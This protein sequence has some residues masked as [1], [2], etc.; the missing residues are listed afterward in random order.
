[1]DRQFEPYGLSHWLV[2]ATFAV[3]AGLLVRAGRRHP[4]PAAAR[5]F[6]R[7]FA[8]VIGAL[9]VAIR[10]A[11]MVPPGLDRSVPLD[12]SDL[13]AVAAA[14]ALWT[15]RHWAFAMTYYWGLA[16]SSQALASP[17]HTGP[18]F[19]HYGFLAFW[20]IHLVVVWAAIYL[21]WGLGM[22]P[23]WRSYRITVAVTVVWAVV[24]FT[25]NSIAGTN[26]GFL[27]AKPAAVSL[28]DVLGPWPWYLVP[29]AVLVLGAWALLTWPW[30]HAGRRRDPEAG[31]RH[32]S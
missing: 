2:I 25:F 6:G 20:A 29:A 8:V 31:S 9:Y 10:V 30:V 23:S 12:V 26:Y 21:T 32:R 11:S 16:L 7:G 5:R 18:D 15:R 1:V 28:L 19:P 17:A 27:N 13:V 22:R 3:G 4:G 24:A 14:Y